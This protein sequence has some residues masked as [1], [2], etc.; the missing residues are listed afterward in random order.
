MQFIYRLF[1][2]KTIDEIMAIISENIII[3]DNVPQGTK[4]CVKRYISEALDLYE[5]ALQLAE[6]PQN[7]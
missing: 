3:E 2:I 6:T 5:F 1:L 4:R 7:H